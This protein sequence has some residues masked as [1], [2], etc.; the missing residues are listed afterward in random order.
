MGHAHRH[1]VWIPGRTTARH[2]DGRGGRCEHDSITDFLTTS[3]DTAQAVAW[4][5]SWQRGNG[6]VPDAEY[7]RGIRKPWIMEEPGIAFQRGVRVRATWFRSV[8]RASWRN[9]AA[10]VGV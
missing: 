9:R 6:L 8:F 1:G 4:E 7:F 5:E 3:G 2:F 10:G